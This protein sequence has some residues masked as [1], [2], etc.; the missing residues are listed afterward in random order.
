MDPQSHT[1]ECTS[2]KGRMVCIR[3]Y[4]GFL[5]GQLGVLDF[6]ALVAREITRKDPQAI[7][8]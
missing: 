2:I 1:H 8:A 3:W 5:N 4:L 6:R 7:E